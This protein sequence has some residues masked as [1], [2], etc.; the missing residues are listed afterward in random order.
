MA[1]DADR[2]RLSEA[3]HQDIFERR[4]APLVLAS[5]QPDPSPTAIVFGGQPGAG[6]S[7]AIDSAARSH[8]S[9][10]GVVQILGDDLRAFHPRYAELMA[11]D[12][13]TAAAYTDRDAGGW[14]EKLI[15]SARERRLNL[16]IE[17]TMRRPEVVE[18]TLGGLRDAGYRTEA[19]VLAIPPELSWLGVLQRYEAQRQDRGYGRMTE[20]S[21]HDAAVEGLPRS[22]ALIEDKGLADRL[23][24][25][26]RG[27]QVLF[28]NEWQPT[29][30]QWQRPADGARIVGAELSRSLTLAER[31][32]YLA[33]LEASS[34]PGVKHNRQNTDP[35]LDGYRT[36]LASARNGLAA[37]ALRELPEQA[38]IQLV[39]SL[40]RSYDVLR[41]MDRR[42]LAEG[43]NSS[44]RAEW[45]AFSKNVLA[46]HVERG[47]TGPLAVWPEKQREPDKG[48][49]R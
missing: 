25:L 4:I 16:I 1:I 7:P 44:Q 32:E 27:D 15:A 26:R 10:R 31:V 24:V 23:L 33:G 39:P 17:G 34:P 41:E 38:A 21:S 13:R 48:I 12:D 29:A 20:R 11:T 46:S 6:K 37:A 45:L 43:W 3:Q 19:R 9:P 49:D 36:L 28:Q 22:V 40:T 2:F 42:A 5:A 47:D 8:P 35:D 18:A 30:K 14:V